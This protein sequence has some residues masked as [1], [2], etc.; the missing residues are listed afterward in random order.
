MFGEEPGADDDEGGLHEFRR[1]DAERADREPAA[2]ALDLGAEEQRQHHHA[3]RDDEQDDGGAAHLA[4]GEEGNADHD[5]NGR[6]QEGGMPLDEVE[7]VEV[8]PLGHRGARGEGQHEAYSHQ[9][10]ERRQ[11]EPVDRPEPVG[12]RPAFRTAHHCRRPSSNRRVGAPKLS[13]RAFP[14]ITGSPPMLS[15]FVLAALSDA[16]AITLRLEM[17]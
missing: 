6:Q 7:A 3:E 16:E 9:Q 8:Q 5:G 13:V 14:A 17:L 11:E 12:H 1:L 15:V 4:R 10:D 2:R